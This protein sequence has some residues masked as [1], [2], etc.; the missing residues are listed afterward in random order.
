[1][2]AFIFLDFKADFLAAKLNFRAFFDFLKW[3]FNFRKLQKIQKYAKKRGPVIFNTA[4][5]TKSSI[6]TNDGF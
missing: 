3:I 2:I 6:M 4:I 5:Y 1:M